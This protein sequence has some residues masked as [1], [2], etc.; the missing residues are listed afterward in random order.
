[1]EEFDPTTGEPIG[2]F[3]TAGRPFGLAV[4]SSDDIYAS[5]LSGI[6]F[7]QTTTGSVETFIPS[8][9]EL[10][11]GTR[12]LTFGVNGNL[13]VV[14][15][16][17]NSIKEFD[18]KTG[19]FLGDFVASGSGG[20]SSPSY[21]T[22]ANVPVPEPSSVLGVVALGGL[23]VGGALQRKVKSFKKLSA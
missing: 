5:D 16:A 21:I 3:P 12:D 4:S 23:F 17:T 9:S 7:R 14:D 22:T 20:L 10:N 11:A 2:G 6:V 19:D 1:M 13:L 15:S 18:S 8:S